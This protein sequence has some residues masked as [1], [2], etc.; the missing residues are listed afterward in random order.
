MINY[1]QGLSKDDYIENICTYFNQD[2][3]QS[4]EPNQTKALV[5]AVIDNISKIFEEASDLDGEEKLL[6]ELKD[7]LE[8]DSFSPQEKL[9]LSCAYGDFCYYKTGSKDSALRAIAAFNTSNPLPTKIEFP[10][11]NEREFLEL[12]KSIFAKCA[13]EMISK[14]EISLRKRKSDEEDDV[15]IFRPKSALSRPLA[16]AAKAEEATKEEGRGSL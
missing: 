8:K 7:I 15:S 14:T 16:T 1:P 4:F 3:T 5:K 12:Q 13:K 9:D 6:K 11:N 2:S 10:Q